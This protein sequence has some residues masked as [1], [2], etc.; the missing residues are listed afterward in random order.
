MHVMVQEPLC[1][2]VSG[3]FVQLGQQQYP[4]EEQLAATR[5]YTP[6]QEP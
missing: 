2:A 6:T 4:H 3:A 5:P 1:R